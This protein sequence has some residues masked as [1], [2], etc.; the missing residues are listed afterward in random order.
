MHRKRGDHVSLPLGD[1]T[2]ALSSVSGWVDVG[3]WV[4]RADG[5]SACLAQSP[6]RRW[7]EL[8]GALNYL[9]HSHLLPGNEDG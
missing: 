7:E 6:V 1:F 3:Q 4:V 8:V 9:Q 2:E 5:D